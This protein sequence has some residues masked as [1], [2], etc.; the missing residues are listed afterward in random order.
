MP[1]RVGSRK[2]TIV[3]FLLLVSFFIVNNVVEHGQCAR[4]KSMVEIAVIVVQPLLIN[5][6]FR[7][8]RSAISIKA[9]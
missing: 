1:I 3:H 2:A 4:L 8:F 7:V 6:S 5:R 9:L